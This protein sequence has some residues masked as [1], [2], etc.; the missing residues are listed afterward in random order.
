[1]K[2]SVKQELR[3]KQRQ[4]GFPTDGDALFADY[5]RNDGIGDG[6]DYN[7]S[8][9]SGFVKS[10]WSFSDAQKRLIYEQLIKTGFT[11]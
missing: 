1:M 11:P 8:L 2:K 4:F 9:I 5:S 6:M 7:E 10:I 3:K